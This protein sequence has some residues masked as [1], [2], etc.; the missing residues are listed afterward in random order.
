[1]HTLTH[2]YIHTLTHSY[3]HTN[4]QTY[5]HT[6]IHTYLHAYIHTYK[7]SSWRTSS[8]ETW[9]SKW[10][11]KGEIQFLYLI[12]QQSLRKVKSFANIMCLQICPD[13]KWPCNFINGIELS[14]RFSQQL[15]ASI[16]VFSFFNQFFVFILQH[17]ASRKGFVLSSTSTTNTEAS[18]RLLDM[19]SSISWLIEDISHIGDGHAMVAAKDCPHK[20]M[21]QDGL[22]VLL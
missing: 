17:Y 21:R 2:S 16:L 12:R 5:K 22:A 7:C 20:L 18:T 3:I 8:W 4:I 14:D 9:T 11:G 19:M 6:Y 1:M 13:H 15:H 10:E